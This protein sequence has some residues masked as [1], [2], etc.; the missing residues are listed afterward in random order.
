MT[1]IEPSVT[2][3]LKAV[4]LCGFLRLRQLQNRHS[5]E[6]VSDAPRWAYLLTSEL[7]RGD[8]MDT[9]ARPSWVTDGCIS[10]ASTLSTHRIPLNRID[11]IHWLSCETAAHALVR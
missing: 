4:G 6:P 9:E 1:D 11:G 5:L 8:S 10:R 3:S 2:R 7:C